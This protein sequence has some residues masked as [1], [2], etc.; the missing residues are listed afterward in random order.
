VRDGV[1]VMAFS[2]ASCSALAV[3]LLLLTRLAG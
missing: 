2:A 3:A 1:A